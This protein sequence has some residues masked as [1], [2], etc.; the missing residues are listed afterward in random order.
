MYLLGSNQT[1]TLG[2]KKSRQFGPSLLRALTISRGS[3]TFSSSWL[4][5]LIPRISLTGL[6]VDLV[7]FFF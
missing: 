4:P 2:L 6:C 5:T 1:R 7:F 3:H